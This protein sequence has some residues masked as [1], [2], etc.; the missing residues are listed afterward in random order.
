MVAFCRTFSSAAAK[1]FTGA[2]ALSWFGVLWAR[3]DARAGQSKPF[4]GCLDPSGVKR[5]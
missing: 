2:V 1:K 4:G 3:R 5:Y